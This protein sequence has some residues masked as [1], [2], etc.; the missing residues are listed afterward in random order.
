MKTYKKG[1]SLIVLIITVIVLGILA[2]TI[3]VSINETNIMTEANEAVIK[4]RFKT[5][6]Q[7]L[8]IYVA[9]QY[10]TTQ[11]SFKL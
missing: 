5:M 4:S 10:A 2:T 8:T 11:G 3:I 9:E 6:Q 1:I 7:Q